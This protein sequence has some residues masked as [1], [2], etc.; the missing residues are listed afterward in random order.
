MDTAG[1]IRRVQNLFG[2][3]N[4]IV[5]T[6]TMIVDWI[7]EG[8]IEIARETAYRT[9]TATDD[10][11]NFRTGKAL[12]DL[13]LMKGISY[14]G[15]PLVV[16]DLETIQR[17]HDPSNFEG[18]PEFYYTD[19]EGVYLFPNPTSTD[20]TTCTIRYV[21]AP[22]DLTD[23]NDSLDIPAKYH[24]D[25]VDYCISK[26]HERNENWRAAEYYLAKFMKGISQRKF[27]AEYRDDTFYSK[28]VDPLDVE[29]DYADGYFS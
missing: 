29:F 15:T 11:S 28:G 20:S 21:D 24:N 7:N 2:D 6:K 14:D 23:E 3:A 13:I 9:A 10:A 19:G 4:E 22:T 1:V 18:V 12:S 16:T 25:L 27:E 5:I 17:M 26:A 8:Q